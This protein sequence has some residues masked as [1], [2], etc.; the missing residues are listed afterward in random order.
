MITKGIDISH[1]QSEAQ[2]NWKAVRDGGI[3]FVY[4]KCTQGS[5]FSDPLCQQ[6]SAGAKLQLI[7]VGYYHFADVTKDP[8]QQANFFKSNLAKLSPY[9]LLPVLDIET[10]STNL[11]PSQIESWTKHFIEA[12]GMPIMLYSYQ[13]FLDENLPSTHSFG[14]I[15]LWLAQYRDIKSPFLP[16]GWSNCSLWQY[17][18]QGKIAGIAIPVDCNKPLTMDFLANG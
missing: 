18:N 14:S 12:M 17:T 6:H 16:H 10:N 8:V 1:F 3:D 9:D 7:A 11:N 15:P 13:P 4:I 5:G 2:I